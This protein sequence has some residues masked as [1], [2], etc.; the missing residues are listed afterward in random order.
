MSVHTKD[1]EKEFQ[2]DQC[3]KGFITK[4]YLERHKIS[5]HLKT[6][7]YNC[8]Y[9]CVFSYNDMANRNAHERK[10]H[11]SLFYNHKEEKLKEKIKM[12]GVDE[13]T[14]ANPII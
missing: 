10:T 11:G 9:G 3:D 5:V 8:R 14:F 6:K 7:P 2:C 13:K 12:L 1:E 4:K